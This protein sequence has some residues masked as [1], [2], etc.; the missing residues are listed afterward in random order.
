MNK[1]TQ[2]KE[3]WDYASLEWIHR[4]RAQIY[5]AEKKRPLIE[6]APRL[7]PEARALA[8]RLSLKTIRAT[9]RPNGKAKPAS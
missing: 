1:K 5:K 9:E 6:L 8:R 2:P 4:A 3:K 7:S